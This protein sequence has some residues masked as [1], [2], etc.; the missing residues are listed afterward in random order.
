MDIIG[1]KGEKYGITFEKHEKFDKRTKIEKVDI[2]S[3]KVDKLA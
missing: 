2:S 3:G 1:A